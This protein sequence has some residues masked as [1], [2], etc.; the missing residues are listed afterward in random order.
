MT[1][2]ADGIPNTTTDF[3][4]TLESTSNV[5]SNKEVSETRIVKR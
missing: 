1:N 5:E 2:S 4:I 3:A